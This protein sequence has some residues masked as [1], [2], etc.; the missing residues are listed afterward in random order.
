MVPKIMGIPFLGALGFL[1][2]LVIAG[3]VFIRFCFRRLR[4]RRQN[5]PKK[6]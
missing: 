3:F 1:A 2:A 5:K 4:Q 6:K